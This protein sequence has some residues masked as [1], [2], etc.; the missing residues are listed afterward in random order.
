MI[1][2][3]I[4][5]VINEVESGSHSHGGVMDKRLGKRDLSS[6]SSRGYYLH[7]NDL[8]KDIYP[9]LLAPSMGK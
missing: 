4:Y 1:I 2:L 3:M 6:N 5:L 9:S 7:V 8:E